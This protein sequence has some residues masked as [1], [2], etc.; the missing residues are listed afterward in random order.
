LFRVWIVLSIVWWLI[1]VVLVAVALIT[2]EFT[3]FN[4]YG[5]NW[6]II[7]TCITFITVP[8]IVYVI[9]AAVGMGLGWIIEG[10]E[11]YREYKNTRNSDLD[12]DDD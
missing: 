7:L 12:E 1:G 4:N 5:S 2:R 3:F 10:F 6:E 11:E 8:F 9:S